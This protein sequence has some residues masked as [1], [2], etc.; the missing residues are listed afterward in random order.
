MAPGSSAEARVP[1]GPRWDSVTHQCGALQD[2][3]DKLLAELRRGVTNQ[4]RNE[5]LARIREIAILWDEVCKRHFGSILEFMPGTG[6]LPGTNTQTLT[7]L[8]PLT[9]R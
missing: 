6:G 9:S 8:K 3:A 7:P 5:I 2:E 4:R 1:D